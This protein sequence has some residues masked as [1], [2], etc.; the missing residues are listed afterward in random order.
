M[1]INNNNNNTVV[2][3][4]KNNTIKQYLWIY[5]Y[6]LIIQQKLFRF[7]S[8]NFV[9]NIKRQKKISLSY[10]FIPQDVINNRKLN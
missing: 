6:K 4:L 3:I 10:C 2:L 9:K 5:I 7:Q 8:N 1:N